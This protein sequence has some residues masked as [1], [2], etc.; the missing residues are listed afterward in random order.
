M[1][2]TYPN[3]GFTLAKLV[4]EDAAAGEPSKWV[5][6]NVTTVPTVAA[7][8]VTPRVPATDNAGTLVDYNNLGSGASNFQPISVS[9][10]ALLDPANAATMGTLSGPDA[11][12]YYTATIVGKKIFPAGARLRSVGLQGYF[13]QVT[14]PGTPKAPIARHAISV[15]KAVAGDDVRRQV[16]DSAKCASCHE[17]FEA[18]GGNRVYQTQVCVHCH[19]PGLT[20]SGRGISDTVLQAYLTAGLL[21][22]ADAAALKTMGITIPNPIPAGSK[23]ALTFPQVNL[24]FKNMVHGIHAGNTRADPI[25][26]VRDRTPASITILNGSEVGYPGILRN[27][28]ACHGYNT[29]SSPIANAFA[30]RDTADNGA[31]VDPESAKASLVTANATDKLTTAFTGACVSCHDAAAAQSHMTKQ[32]GQIKV[33]RSDL[34]PAAESCV[35]CHGAGKQF[36]PVKVHKL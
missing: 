34:T 29:C 35:V 16:V 3:L 1:V 26:I 33:S 12:G 8:A 19:V 24:S 22:P 9:I 17:W 36:D 27:C 5:S 7:P 2:A 6:Y 32:G 30:S 13:S 4:P 14:A 11:N 10:A 25:E 15:V 23:F 31:V 18:H 28:E 21:L 20:S